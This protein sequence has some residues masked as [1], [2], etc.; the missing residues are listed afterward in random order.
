M[1]LIGRGFRAGSGYRYGFNGKENDSETKTQDY[2]ARILN[3]RLGRFLSRDPLSAS[4]PYYTPYQFAGNTPIQA[5]DLDGEEPIGYS[6]S[7]RFKHPGR[8]WIRTEKDV[9]VSSIVNGNWFRMQIKDAVGAQWTVFR[10]ETQEIASYGNYHRLETKV[11]FYYLDNSI[12]APTPGNYYVTN[13][14]GT[15]GGNLIAFDAKERTDMKQGSAIADGF[16]FMAV[17]IVAAPAVLEVAPAM[18]SFSIPSTKAELAVAATKA[19]VGGVSDLAA[20]KTTSP[21]KPI[22]WYSVGTNTA[23]GFFSLN[24]Y[25]TAGLAS[26][27]EYNE[28]KGG[29][30]LSTGTHF[31]TNTLINGSVNALTGKSNMPWN[32]R[33]I[34]NTAGEKV[35]GTATTVVPQ[36]WL[37][38]ATNSASDAVN[39]K[40][41]KKE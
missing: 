28:K 16:S 1:Q 3:N 21:D 11:D 30:T 9:S 22:N 19:I 41:D 37:G 34:F 12:N 20:Q 31:L 17:G 33:L 15:F 18:L 27:M 13:P 6:T 24:A 14:D 4:Y 25:T 7:A 23:G 32:K 2:G 26:T 35:V 36:Y 39:D 10:Q 5:V 8:E 29:F 38:T 40:L